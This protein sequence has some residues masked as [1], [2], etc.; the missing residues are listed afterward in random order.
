[1]TSPIHGYDSAS[2]ASHNP[3]AIAES[4]FVSSA[5]TS[6]VFGMQIDTTLVYG[7][8]LVIE[9]TGNTF[10]VYHD[11]IIVRQ[12]V[13][14]T[15]SLVTLQLLNANKASINRSIAFRL[16]LRSGGK[17]RV[18]FNDP[19]TIEFRLNGDGLLMI[20]PNGG[21]SSLVRYVKYALN[22]WP[23]YH[24][25][26]PLI[27]RSDGSGYN[28]SDASHLL[29][30]EYGG[31]GV[32]LLHDEKELYDETGSTPTAVYNVNSTFSDGKQH[33][34]WSA[35][36]PPKRYNFRDA[37]ARDPVWM[38]NYWSYL[39]TGG[40]RPLLRD[41]T[42]EM[43]FPDTTFWLVSAAKTNAL[44]SQFMSQ[45]SPF[46]GPGY[47][48]YSGDD[49]LWRDWLFSYVPRKSLNSDPYALL[50]LVFQ[51]VH[52]SG[53]KK[54]LVYTSPQYFLR[55]SHFYAPT[56]NGASPYASHGFY[57]DNGPNDPNYNVMLRYNNQ[58]LLRGGAQPAGRPLPMLNSFYMGKAIPGGGL[59]VDHYMDQFSHYDY[60][61]D[62]YIFFPMNRE[63][64][65]MWQYID[66]IHSLWANC[67]PGT[68]SSL[69]GVY[70]DTFYEFNIPR[71][72]QLM[73][74]L[75]KSFGSNFLLFRH[76]SA[77]EGQDAYLP[78]ID[79]YA[80][81][82]M[83][84]EANDSTDYYDRTRFRFFN[85]TYN[86]S[87]AVAY[88]FK[89]RYRLDDSASG[90]DFLNR[91]Y[92]Y[93]IHAMY[94]AISRTA[95][96]K[97]ADGLPNKDS[98]LIHDAD[99]YWKLLPASPN[100]SMRIEDNLSR[101]RN[102]ARQFDTTPQLRF[103]AGWKS[104]GSD[105][106]FTGDFNGDGKIDLGVFRMDS[107]K[108]YI[109]LSNSSALSSPVTGTVVYGNTTDQPVIGDF[110]GDGR[111]DLGDWDRIQG[112]FNIA[113]S[114]CHSQGVSFGQFGTPLCLHVTDPTLLGAIVNAGDVDGDGK[115]D[116]ILYSADPTNSANGR[117]TIYKGGGIQTGFWTRPPY[118][119][120]Q[121]VVPGG[122]GDHPFVG[123]FTGGGKCEFGVFH[124]VSAGPQSYVSQFTMYSVTSWGTYTRASGADLPLAK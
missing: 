65:N 63:G 41:W 7:D 90:Y 72:Y 70:M 119:P 44:T 94:P 30:D 13:D 16:G 10:V 107:S 23:A 71:T 111:A 29:M 77:K 56:T 59:A 99:E 40:P 83:T 19:N 123:D 104:K 124:L 66:A 91:M 32:Y 38:A 1:M 6:A 118:P 78:Q 57:L 54:T 97:T 37:T 115:A 4:L 14:T 58:F 95:F 122:N 51:N 100:D 11:M 105:I 112:W 102:I 53:G 35:F 79:A 15:R 98:T 62:Q 12:T 45:S 106:P 24:A 89:P 3:W 108:W 2:Y 82:V 96:V 81:F 48:I 92:D 22:F 8:S 74:E 120:M 27:P 93:N 55:G 34:L 42:S 116:L 121:I 88:L 25:S 113:L 117:F 33:I 87:N 64:E 28:K 39:T 84:G 73:R 47:F 61:V 21:T 31:F 43:L 80:N 69:D 101:H 86:I 67:R 26:S 46:N 50:K 36:F 114:S 110:D 109:S 76:A 49:G 60:Y 20:R 5:D 68:D 52:A 9:T 103:G 17:G 85:S 18:C 75:R